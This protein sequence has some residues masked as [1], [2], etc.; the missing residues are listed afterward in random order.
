MKTKPTYTR[1]LEWVSIARAKPNP[2][3]QRRFDP[4][5]ADEI[6][7]EFDPDLLGYPLLVAHDG[8]GDSEQY[9]TIDGQHR[10]AACAKALGEDQQIQC[11][12]VRGIDLVRAAQ[13]FLGRQKTKHPKPFDA[14][15]VGVTGKDPEC[16]AINSVVES[17]GLKVATTT[18]QIGVVSAVVALRRIFRPPGGSAHLREVLQITKDAW[19]AEAGI[20]QGDVLSGLSLFLLRYGSR[21]DRANL[22]ARLSSSTGGAPGLLGRGRTLRQAFGGPVYVNVARALLTLYN[23]GR[24]SGQLPAW[25]AK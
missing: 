11:E 2:Q 13:L 23:S 20:F 8:R 21:V 18:S 1:S 15:L 25:D 6:A 7:A 24:R 19:E 22:H 4:A 16:V 10:L 12:V 17:V 14:F 9:F 5:W 3:A